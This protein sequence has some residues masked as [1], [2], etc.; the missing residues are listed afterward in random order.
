MPLPALTIV[1]DD[2]LHETIHRFLTESQS[3]V[4]DI[5]D[6]KDVICRMISAGYMFAMD[7]DR[8]RDAI[9]DF[10]YVCQPSDEVNKDRIMKSLEYEDE[11]SDD[12]SE[13]EFPMSGGKPQCTGPDENDE[14][15]RGSNLECDRELESQ[16]CES[17][18]CESQQCESQQCESQQCESQQCES[19]DK[20]EDIGNC[21]E[22]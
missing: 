8:L 18:Q 9:E 4:S 11:M 1:R 5:D 6:M 19:Q 3:V 2:M 17:Q 21:S 13:I 15:C 10:S 16:Q 7:R 12:E 22:K 14:C 20:I